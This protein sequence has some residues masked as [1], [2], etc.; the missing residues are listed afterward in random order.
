MILNDG[1]FDVFSW[2]G[3]LLQEH[4]LQQENLWQLSAWSDGGEDCTD[5]LLINLS[6]SQPH[7]MYTF[8]CTHMQ[9]SKYK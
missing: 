3:C 8:E 9:L 6:W 2:I 7:H 1:G 4:G 5:L